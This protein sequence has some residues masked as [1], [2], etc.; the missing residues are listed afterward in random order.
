[1]PGG[2]EEGGGGDWRP[3]SRLVLASLLLSLLSVVLSVLLTVLLLTRP[4]NTHIL[5]RLEDLEVEH[6]YLVEEVEGLEE[7]RVSAVCLLAPD[8]GPC[9]SSVRRFYFLPRLEDCLEF[10]WGGCQGNDNNFLSLRQCRHTCGVSSPPS[11]PPSTPPS[12]SPPLPSPVV[13]RAGSGQDCQEPV[14]SGPCTDRLARFFFQS[15][16]QSCQRWERNINI[17]L[18]LIFNIIPGLTTGAVAGMET[19]TSV[20]RTVS[21]AA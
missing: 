10:P 6:D 14:D 8:P 5:Q 13:G 16:T 9:T 19:I 12:S 17:K 1:M 3:H 2:G 18:I 4:G 7:R 11:S 20:C 15:E 21:G